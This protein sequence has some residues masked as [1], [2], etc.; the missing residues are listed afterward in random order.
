MEQRLQAK[1]IGTLVPGEQLQPPLGCD[2]NGMED[3]T[4]EEESQGDEEE[5]VELNELIARLRE[6]RKRM[7]GRTISWKTQTMR[8][9]WRCLKLSYLWHQ[10]PLKKWSIGN[11]FGGVS[12][13]MVV[14]AKGKLHQAVQVELSVV[15]MVTAGNH[16]VF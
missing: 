7:H 3:L 5:A 2:F 9:W 15:I 4:G 13:V 16:K 11:N 6:R 12:M 10:T 8:S 14:R 1:F